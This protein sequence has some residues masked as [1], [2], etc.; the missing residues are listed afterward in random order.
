[1]VAAVI[2]ISFFIAVLVFVVI[3]SLKQQSWVLS[4]MAK[5][6]KVLAVTTHNLEE[7]KARMDVMLVRQ[8]NLIECFSNTHQAAEFDASMSTDGSST[9]Q[10]IAAVKNQLNS[11]NVKNLAETEQ[12]QTLEVL[13]EGTFGKV[14]KGLWRG[15]E[16][17]IKTMMLPANMSGTEKREKMAVMEVRTPFRPLLLC[18]SLPPLTLL[19]SLRLPSAPHSH[20]PT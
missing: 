1:V 4:E 17:A 20:T 10:R 15:T 14:Y 16:V 18:L 13:G 7:E 12:V 11:D 6:N 2:I 19:M 3:V 8:F 5:V 9:A